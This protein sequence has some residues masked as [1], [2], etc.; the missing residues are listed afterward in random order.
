[1][2]FNVPSDWHR[3]IKIEAAIRGITVTNLII[4]AVN[5][6]LKNNPNTEVDNHGKKEV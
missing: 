2:T 1:M 6:W 4:E 5:E 3:K